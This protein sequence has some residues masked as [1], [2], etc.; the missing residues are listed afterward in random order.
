MS[1]SVGDATSALSLQIHPDMTQLKKTIF[2]NVKHFQKFVSEKL[3]NNL[4]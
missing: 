3:Q 2:L 1:F 4:L